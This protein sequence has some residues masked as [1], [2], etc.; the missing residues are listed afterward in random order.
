MKIGRVYGKIPGSMDYAIIKTSGSQ[1]L[2]TEGQ[3]L[4]LPNLNVA[5]G[6]D[7]EFEVL[8][9][10][11]GDKLE[12]GMPLVS[13]AKVMGKVVRNF[14]DEKV[15]VI[16]FK[17]KS[18]YR[19]KMGFRAQLTAVEIMSLTGEKKAVKAETSE[20]EVVVPKVKKVSKT[21]KKVV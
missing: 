18:R 6:K 21:S 4:D 10:K 12:I 9:S 20:K 8:L 19:R 1:Y 2:V 15:D 11:V 3:R 16:K 17:A 7:I 13:G 5:E 14:K